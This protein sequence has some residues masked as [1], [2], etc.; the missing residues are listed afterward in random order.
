MNYDEEIE[1]LLDENQAAV[2]L[3]KVG[4]KIDNQRTK[5]DLQLLVAEYGAK[6]SDS[7]ELCRLLRITR[8]SSEAFLVEDA[9]MEKGDLELAQSIIAKT[10]PSALPA[11]M[12]NLV[13]LAVTVI[14]P[15]NQALIDFIKFK[16]KELTP[17]ASMQFEMWQTHVSTKER[18]PANLVNLMASRVI[19]HPN[20]C[21][22]FELCH[23]I[24]SE[25]KHL[26]QLRVNSEEAEKKQTSA[27]TVSLKNATMKLQQHNHS[28]ESL[29][30][31]LQ[32]LEKATSVFARDGKARPLLEVLG[33]Y[34]ADSFPATS[35]CA[36]LIMEAMTSALNEQMSEAAAVARLNIACNKLIQ[37]QLDSGPLINIKLLRAALQTKTD[38]TA[39]KLID[40]AMARAKCQPLRLAILQFA[41]TYFH[42][43]H[44]RHHDYM[45]Q[46]A[47]LKWE[48]RL[49][50]FG[51]KTRLNGEGT[52]VEGVCYDLLGKSSV[53]L[54]FVKSF[55]NEMRISPS[56]F[57][58]G[59][60]KYHL[61]GE[62]STDFLSKDNGALVSVSKRHSPFSGSVQSLGKN[63]PLVLSNTHNSVTAAVWSQTSKRL[64]EIIRMFIDQH[65]V[66]GV[67]DVL[68]EAFALV[69]K[70]EYT[71]IRFILDQINEVTAITQT[72]NVSLNHSR[73]RRLLDVFSSYK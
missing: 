50:T 38:S 72:M 37:K 11:I 60:L 1:A 66:A 63:S 65:N 31:F 21:R 41:A 36:K 45:S 71:R 10:P 62:Q 14:A 32:R 55:C 30:K 28:Q 40:E 25:A 22:I 56:D 54:E 58:F 53:S 19:A 39:A 46:V 16:R 59:Y 43:S 7:D 49:E 51:L 48:I 47:T 15:R 8:D 33:A 61:L 13:N 64:G 23:F 35:D 67:L 18:Q 12:E 34:K 29:D 70:N 69:D 17:R 42:P 24:R 52:R 20:D 73:L 27:A 68:T 2:M 5:R 44:P 4:L 9:L 3:A 6:A 57:F 26:A